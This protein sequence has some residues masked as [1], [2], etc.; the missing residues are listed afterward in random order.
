MVWKSENKKDGQ[1]Q[2]KTIRA[3]PRSYFI[4]CLEKRPFVEMSMSG[5]RRRKTHNTRFANVLD[6]SFIT[7]YRTGCT[8]KEILQFN[9]KIQIEAIKH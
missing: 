2:S 1:P 5:R 4:E 3:H 9:K 8:V 6:P 7:A